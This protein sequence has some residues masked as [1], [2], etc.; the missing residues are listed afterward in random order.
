MTRICSCVYYLVR[1]SHVFE[2]GWHVRHVE[3]VALVWPKLCVVRGGS[4]GLDF[5]GSD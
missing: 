2:D 4:D 1:A 3:C 5:G